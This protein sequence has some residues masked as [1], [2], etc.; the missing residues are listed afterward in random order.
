[1]LTGAQVTVG[2]A[3]PTALNILDNDVKGGQTLI[4]WCTAI[5]ALGDAN[6]TYAAGAQLPANTFLTVDLDPTERLYAI[7]SGSNA[8]V[9]VVH[10]GV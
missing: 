9:H 4:F 2:T 8:T 6:V 3:T 10:Q 7:A 5:I 1:M